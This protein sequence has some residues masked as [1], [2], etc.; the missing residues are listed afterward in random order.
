[1]KSASLIL[2]SLLVALAARAPAQSPLTSGSKASDLDALKTT[3]FGTAGTPANGNLI[4]N[5]N[6]SDPTPLKSYRYDFPYQD[7]Y[8]D[9]AKYVTQVNHGGKNCAQLDL[10]EHLVGN[11]G[12]KV[13]TALVPAVPGATYRVEVACMTNDFAA[14]VHAEAYAVDPR[15]EAKRTD[16]ES[17]GVKVTIMRIPP[18]NGQPALV[19]IYRKQ[20]PDPPAHSKKWDNVKSEFTLPLEWPV[21]GEKAKPAFLTIKATVYDATEAAGKSYF[22]DFRLTKIKDPGASTAPKSSGPA[23]NKDAV[24]R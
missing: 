8:K 17:K 19:E 4:P 24:L 2:A 21:A 18:M 15:A 9:N 5:W 14:K 1:M 10:P 16:D 20:L 11:G 22:T 6:M 13:E 7:F 3:K 23:S 12:A